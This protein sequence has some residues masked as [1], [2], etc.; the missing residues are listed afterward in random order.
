MQS[1]EHLHSKGE[2]ASLGESFV[3]SRTHGKEQRAFFDL[4]HCAKPWQVHHSVWASAS[5]QESGRDGFAPH[6]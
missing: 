1:T 5:A 3:V 6:F 2:A 4:P